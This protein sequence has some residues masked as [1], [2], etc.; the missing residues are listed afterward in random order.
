MT[1]LCT[2]LFDDRERSEVIDCLLL[3]ILG[4]YKNKRP[5]PISS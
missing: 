2:V 3:A 1:A 4:Y 5:P